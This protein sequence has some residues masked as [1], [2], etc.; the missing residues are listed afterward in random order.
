MDL[1]AVI[2]SIHIGLGMI[3]LLSGAVSMLAPKKKGRHT[4][5]G[6]VYHGA[7]AALAATA[8][9]LAIWKWNEIAY[10]FYIAVFSYGLAVYGYL[11]R[12]QKWKSWLRHHISGMLGSY[13]GAVTALLVNIGDGIPLLNKLPA[14]SYWFLPTI[15]GSPL[16]YIVGRRYRKKPS[17]TKKISY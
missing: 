15:I 2:L 10:L 14:L 3:C 17:V 6:N 4:R 5:W 16:I 13:I 1:F 11:A 7:Y 8:I 9:I 12:K